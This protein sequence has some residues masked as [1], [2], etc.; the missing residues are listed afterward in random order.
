[1]IPCKKYGLLT[2]VA[3]I[4]AVVAAPAIAG[5]A[6][7]DS[8][9]ESYV[10]LVLKTGLYNSDYVDYYYGPEEWQIPN[11][12]E[13]KA[14]YPL[15]AL[16]GEADSLI[17]QLESIEPYG[18]LAARGRFL[19]AQLKAVRAFI[20]QL[21]GVRLTFDQE[22]KALYDV[23]APH[24][25]YAYYDS[26]FASIDSL[27]PGNGEITERLADYHNRYTVPP[28]KVQSIMDTVTAHAREITR[29]YI[30][31]PTNE[32]VTLEYVTDKPWEGF[33]KFL[34]HG[35]SLVQT[36]ID[37]PLRLYGAVDGATHEVYPGHHTNFAMIEKRLVLDSG[38]MEYTVLP[39]FTPWAVVAE[40]IATYAINIAFPPEAR[41]QYFRDRVFP[42]AGFDGS[43]A[44]HYLNVM[45]ARRELGNVDEVI[46]REYLDGVID[47]LAAAALLKKYYG[48]GDLQA[49]NSISFYDTYRSYIVTYSVGYELVRD[50]LATA[51]NDATDPELR[52]RAFAA[53]L[54][55]PIT[56]S[57]LT[58]E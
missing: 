19:A 42:L 29:Q 21:Q 14:Q 13:S 5:D 33:C 57:D 47:S 38:W 50:Y 12:P 4:V 10:K 45:A 32:A 15:S 58:V 52:W 20:S 28:D 3:A 54:S 1:M 49:G 51:T 39:I 56:P 37:L 30:D 6:N 18:P 41:L 9:A 43:E 7:L 24:R 16:A 27:L 55:A 17:Q 35:R 11:T 25:D 22:S 36:N 2:V 26:V 23:V 44:E 34:G 31:L 53:L 46:A 8:I 48:Q 40:G